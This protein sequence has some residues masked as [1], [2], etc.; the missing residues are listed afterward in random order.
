[1][2]SNFCSTFAYILVKVFSDFG[3]IAKGKAASEIYPPTIPPS[4]SF[5]GYGFNHWNTRNYTEARGDV[6]I[7]QLRQQDISILRVSVLVRARPWLV[8]SPADKTSFCGYGFNHWT[9]LIYTEPRIYVSCIRVNPCSSVGDRS[10]RCIFFRKNR[11]FHIFL[12]K[13]LLFALFIC[14]FGFFFV[15]LRAFGV[16]Y[17]SLG[18]YVAQKGTFL[19]Y[20]FNHYHEN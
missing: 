2:Y 10:P 5:C 20:I 6:S 14:Q 3:G 9:T 8:S 18:N 16:Q 19:C 11:L 1:M 4:K 7:R 17:N 13:F 12:T 15:P